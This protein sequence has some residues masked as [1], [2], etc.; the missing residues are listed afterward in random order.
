MFDE[1]LSYLLRALL[2]RAREQIS[3]RQDLFMTYRHGKPSSRSRHTALSL[4]DVV[5]LKS[6]LPIKSSEQ[7][8]VV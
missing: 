6:Y 8:I 7:S 1:L 4:T 3:W 5:G 2:Y